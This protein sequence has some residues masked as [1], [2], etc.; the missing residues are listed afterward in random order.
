MLRK[1]KRCSWVTG[2]S[3]YIKYHDCEWGVPIYNDKNIFECLL[4][5]SFQAGLSWIIILKKRD[6]FRKSFDGF[7]YKKIA[8][9]SKNKI[10]ELENDSGIVRNK[11][12]IKAAKEN[13]MCYIKIQK[14]FG[15]FSNYIWG[16]VN[17]TPIHYNP[18]SARKL[19]KKISLDMKKRGFKFIGPTIIYSFIESIGLANNHAKN[20]F[21]YQEIK[22]ISSI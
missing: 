18:K 4:L 10:K 12:K 7:D 13:A 9:Y 11:L 2:S 8:K 21:R 20:C 17:Y 15:S 22:S 14:E 1:I 19:A 3:L 5:E 16:F 6:N